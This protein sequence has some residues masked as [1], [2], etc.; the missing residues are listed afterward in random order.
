[1]GTWYRLHFYSKVNYF[2]LDSSSDSE[3]SSGQFYTIH[4][5]KERQK[6]SKHKALQLRPSKICVTL[7]IGQGKL[8][9]CMPVKV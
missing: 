1:M 7:S 3:E 4:D 8:T 2:F 9:A 5:Q 6:R